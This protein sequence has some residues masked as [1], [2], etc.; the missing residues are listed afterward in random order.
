MILKKIIVTTLVFIQSLN[1]YTAKPKILIIGDSISI[2]YTP[3]V[4]E[5]LSNKYDVFHNPGNAQHTGTGL[6]N[7]NKWIGNEEWDIIQF[8]WGLWD[9]CYRHPDSKYQGNR[10]KINGKITFSIEDYEANLDSIIKILKTKTKAKL[11]FVT[12]SYVPKNEVGRFQND[13]NKYNEAAIKIMK[14]N[15][16]PINDIYA[17]SKKIHNKYGLGSDDVHYKPEGYKELS[18]LIVNFIE[19]EIEL[20]KN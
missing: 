14:K 5:A 18:K 20:S 6:E 13:A 19:N 10:D 17:K 12:T 7:I 3:F 4:K 16:I 1:E 15:D 11:V 9:L 8:N 2:G